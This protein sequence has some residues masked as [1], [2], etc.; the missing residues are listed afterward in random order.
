MRLEQDRRCIKPPRI[1]TRGVVTKAIASRFLVRRHYWPDRRR[2]GLLRSPFTTPPRT[3]S[4]P[5]RNRPVALRRRDIRVN[6]LSPG[7]VDIAFL[8]GMPRG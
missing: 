7:P 1:S 8:E 2:D 3:P 6:V 4:A 5:S